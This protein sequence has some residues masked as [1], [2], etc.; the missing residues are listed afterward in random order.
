MGMDEL[1]E[2]YAEILYVPT[3]GIAA[4]DL[5]LA[6]KEYRLNNFVRFGRLSA[7]DKLAVVWVYALME[8]DDV[9]WRML[10]R[11]QRERFDPD[12]LFIKSN[13]SRNKSYKPYLDFID[14]VA[15]GKR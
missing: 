14:L 6:Y 11:E 7:S 10:T 13:P 8:Y 3:E 12:K 1:L 15:T 9:Q 2:K 5:F 4:E